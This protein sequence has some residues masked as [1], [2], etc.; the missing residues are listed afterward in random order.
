[1]IVTGCALGPTNKMICTG[2]VIDQ[3][4]VKAGDYRPG[5]KTAAGAGF[6]AMGGAGLGAATGAIIGLGVTVATLGFATPSIPAFAATGAAIGAGT[7][8]GMGGAV[9]YGN[10]LVS[11]G[12]DLYDYIV[13]VDGSNQRLVVRQIADPPIPN[14][15]KVQVYEKK[16]KYEMRRIDNFWAK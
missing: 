6:G 11:R 13:K 8:A 3:E 7:G 15:A 16:G 4:K 12:H 1:M 2:T 5:V 10:D 14:N 9:G